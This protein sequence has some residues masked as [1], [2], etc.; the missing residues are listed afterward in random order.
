MRF[1]LLYLYAL[2]C[3]SYLLS[4]CSQNLLTYYKFVCSGDFVDRGSFSV[5]VIL[6]LFAFKVLYPE[7]LHLSRGNHESQGMNATFGFDGE[8]SCPQTCRILKRS[9]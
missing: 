5:E 7:H 2:H 1:F 6:T 4:R 3:P 9:T 8:V